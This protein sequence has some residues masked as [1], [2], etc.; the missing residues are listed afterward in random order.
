MQTLRERMIPHAS[1]IEGMV[2]SNQYQ[3]RRRRRRRRRKSNHPVPLMRSSKTKHVFR[4]PVVIPRS[5]Y[6]SARSQAIV[7]KDNI[8][9][10]SI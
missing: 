5:D 10:N 9:F 2:A 1:E 8:I 3:R 4:Q 7:V 6:G